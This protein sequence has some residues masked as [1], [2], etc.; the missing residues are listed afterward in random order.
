MCQKIGPI[1][2]NSNSPRNT[3]RLISA[4]RWWMNR[5]TIILNWLRASMVRPCAAMLVSGSGCGVGPIWPGTTATSG[6]GS[7]IANPRVKE[8]VQHVRDDVEDDDRG[9]RHDQ[10]ALNDVN[11]RADPRPA[12]GQR[13]VEQRAHSVPAVDDLGD[14]HDAEQAREVKRDHGG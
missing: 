2:E 3:P 1:V 14:D 7:G 11:V 8:R 12:A 4:T 5:S 13:V 6:T 9:R 10:P